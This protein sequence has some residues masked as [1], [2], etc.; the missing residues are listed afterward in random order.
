[1]TVT[2]HTLSH[3]Q[4]VREFTME[5]VEPLCTEDYVVQASPDVSPPKWHMA[6]TTWFFET[7]ILKKYKDKYEDFHPDYHYLFNSYYETVGSFYPRPQRGLLSRPTVLDIQTYREHVDRQMIE[8]LETAEGEELRHIGELVE[9]GLHHERQHQELLLT[10]IK[11]NFSINPLQPVY[12][13]QRKE[14]KALLQPKTDFHEIE[15]G[16]VE[17]GHDEKGFSFDNERP[18]HKVWLEPYCL[19]SHPV[20]NGEFLEFIEDGGYE[21][22]EY[23]LSDGWSVVKEASWHAPLYWEKENE[24]WYSFTLSG[25]REIAWDEPVCHVSFYEADAFARWAGKRLPTEAEWEHAMKTE[26]VTGNFAEERIFHPVAAPPRDTRFSQA[27]GDVWEWTGS[28]YASYPGHRP[29]EG[30][31]GEYNA[32]FMSNQLVLRGG[33][34]VSAADH[35]RLTYRNFFHPEKRWQFSGF[36]LAEGVEQS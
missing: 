11:Y 20:T 31:L 32:K 35:I 21:K 29:L 23:W 2:N 18:V 27:F 34:C 28:P 10:D 36:R 4:K 1:M 9:L 14:E 19:A 17:I 30:S 3:F 16:L 24:T 6:H 5:L 15:G 7:F 33:S 12:D 25:K 13:Q 8:L 22:P 26:A